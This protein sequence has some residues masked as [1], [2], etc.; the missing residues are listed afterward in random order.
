V[1]TEGVVGDGGEDMGGCLEVGAPDQKHYRVED[2]PVR[3][4]RPREG[5]MVVFPSYVW[6][7]ILPFEGR[8]QRISYAFDV[9]PTA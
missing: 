7:R 5:Y 3:V 4:F 6:H 8:G 1:R 9:V 2:Y